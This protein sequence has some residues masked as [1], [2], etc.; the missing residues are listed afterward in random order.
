MSLY[1]GTPYDYSAA[2]GGL[3]FTVGACPLDEEGRVVAPGDRELQ[4]ACAVENLLAALAEHFPSGRNR[5]SG[6]TQATTEPGQRIRSAGSAAGGNAVDTRYAVMPVGEPRRSRGR[7]SA[8]SRGAAR[9]A[10]ASRRAMRCLGSISSRP[11]SWPVTLRPDR[12]D[13]RRRIRAGSS[14]ARFTARRK[15]RERQGFPTAGRGYGVEVVDQGSAS[16]RWA[17]AVATLTWSMWAQRSATPLRK[18]ATGRSSVLTS[19]HARVPPAGMPRALD[20]EWFVVRDFGHTDPRQRARGV[21][22]KLAKRLELIKARCPSAIDTSSVG[23]SGS[24][25]T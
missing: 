21:P 4:A 5:L 3:I 12:F 25:T 20:R 16:P 2:A 22:F 11:R 17:Y 1:P 18:S 8:R 13:Q 15:G 19:A 6:P 9:R 7:A 24:F 14:T 10:V 23:G